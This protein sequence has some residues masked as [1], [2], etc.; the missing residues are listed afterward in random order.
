MGEHKELQI[1]KTEKAGLQNDLQ[2][3]D[4]NNKKII[5]FNFIH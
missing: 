5:N 2:N 1:Q 4:K 3:N